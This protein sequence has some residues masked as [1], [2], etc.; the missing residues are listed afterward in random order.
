VTTDEEFVVDLNPP[1]TMDPDAP[2]PRTKCFLPDQVLRVETT[3]NRKRTATALPF[4]FSMEPGDGAQRSLARYGSGTDDRGELHDHILLRRSSPSRFRGLLRPGG[5]CS[6]VV[7]RREGE[8][9]MSGV[10]ACAE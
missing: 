7:H 10:D 2:L 8:G 9:V 3:S 5:I 1:A 6:E 4:L